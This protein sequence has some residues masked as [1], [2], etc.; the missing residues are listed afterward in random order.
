M[1]PRTLLLVT[2]YFP[3]HGGGAAVRML[4]L[5]KYLSREGWRVLVL[6]SDGRRHVHLDPDLLQ[7]LPEDVLVTRAASVEASAPGLEKRVAGGQGS[8][9]LLKPLVR[10]KR[11]L[12]FPDERAG[13][14]PAAA[15]AGLSLLRRFRPDAV[16][17]SSPPVTAHLVGRFLARRFGLP[18]VADFR[19]GWVSD[20]LADPAP[21]AR[22]RRWEA[23]LVRDAAA[24]LGATPGIAEDFQARYPGATGKVH[25]IP[26]GFD[27]EDRRYAA[28]HGAPRKDFLLTSVGVGRYTR[29]IAPVLD[30]LAG[31]PGVRLRLVGS[32]FPAAAA[33]AR[34]K[35]VGDRV[36]V[37]PLM[38]RH[39]ALALLGES[40]AS[41]LVLGAGADSRS[42]FA[43]SLFDYLMI[44]KPLLA[45]A[46]PG[47]AADL[48]AASGL[49]R[50]VAPGDPAA[51]RKALDDLSGSRTVPAVCR[52]ALAP[53]DRRLQAARIS[54]LLEGLVGAQRQP[55]I[56]MVAQYF[57]PAAGGSERQACQQAEDLAAEG[58]P[59]TALA[60]RAR[61]VREQN[62]PGVREIRVG[63][64]DSPGPL[65]PRSLAVPFSF[66][67]RIAAH[68]LRHGGDYDVLHLHG[69]GLPAMLAVPAAKLRGLRIL[70]KVSAANTGWEAGSLL[71]NGCWGP[72]GWLARRIFRG[73]DCW[74]AISG[75]VARGLEADGM[76]PGRIRRLPNGVDLSRFRALSPAER[77]EARARLGWPASA[78]VALV[79]GRLVPFKGTAPFVSAWR[80]APKPEGTLLAV[81]G[82]GPERARLEADPSVRLLGWRRDPEVLMGAADLLVH[83]SRD[84]E[85]M[86][87]V[88]AEAM[89]CGLPVAAFRIGGVEDL[90]TDG[91]EGVLGTE[92]DDA[93]LARA[94]LSLLADP[95]RLESLGHA[96]RRRAGDFD[97]RRIAREL[98]ACYR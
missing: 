57:D 94:A 53:Y 37:F 88:V 44:G 79:V 36:E 24:V 28:G 23:R 46:D 3:P 4:K 40:D 10:L 48:V 39:K 78:K 27:P 14:G 98:L 47:P 17:S 66:G 74:I 21:G 85:G 60:R 33:L 77:A 87:N 1:K 38:G 16:L 89:A 68:L 95:G 75:A 67:C 13:W 82:D 81:A 9:L 15:L 32:T 84:Q 92:G 58:I 6:T 8:A 52:E 42:S 41:L 63:D 22:A 80:N 54:A 35:G 97:R 7:E 49:G 93:G 25:W 73:V 56:L 72:A 30:A 55:R 83:P 2:Y 71:K 34:E 50:A 18:W 96:A 59:V 29:D 31:A 26:N 76:E 64:P 51:I 5:A 91:V 90:V 61:G 11:R 69:A 86:P 19:D 43:T 65:E 62:L 45:V 12:L 70:A 20:P